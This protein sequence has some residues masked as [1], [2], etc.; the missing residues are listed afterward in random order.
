MVKKCTLLS[1]AAFSFL[2]TGCPWAS[3]VPEAM[4][5]LRV[6]DESANVIET[7]N[8]RVGFE[9]PG[10]GENSARQEV[11]GIS[12][13]NGLFS[14]KG[15]TVQEI[16]YHV[17]KAGYYESYGQ[18]KFMAKE[19]G[20]W[21]PWNQEKVVILRKVENPV[22]M[23][24]VDLQLTKVLEFPAVGVGIGFDLV[25]RDWVV[26]YGK[27]MTSDFILKA[28]RDFSRSNQYDG[29]LTISFPNKYDGMI[30]FKD[31]R[32][33]GSYFKLPRHAPDNGYQPTL[34]A[35]V[36][37]VP[38]QPI[39][40]TFAEDNNYFFRIRSEEKNGKMYRAMYGK[41]H[42]DFRFD[43]VGTKTALLTFKYYL[44]PDYSK[45]MEFDPRNNLFKNLDRSEYIGLE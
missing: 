39:E 1:I 8:I 13:S 30:Q 24:A 36:K 22:P 42:G 27:G 41:I 45:N 3:N 6:V 19:N 25:E 38:G 17:T 20:R 29:V 9:E 44:N 28:D 12:D 26:P 43:L 23:Y 10:N 35:K 21:Q 4:I 34:K 31:D 15:K 37:S 16:G 32:K 2:L 18:Y 7:A 33:L 14:A 5:T 11:K 40:I